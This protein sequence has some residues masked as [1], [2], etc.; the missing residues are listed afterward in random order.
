MSSERNEGPKKKDNPL[1][2]EDFLKKQNNFHLFFAGKPG[3]NMI[4]DIYREKDVFVEALKNPDFA[5]IVDQLYDKPLQS[6]LASET[7]GLNEK[8]YRAYLIMRNCESYLNDWE[9]LFI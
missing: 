1:I 6:K 9:S 4:G 3:S 5:A 2:I 7:D 8:L